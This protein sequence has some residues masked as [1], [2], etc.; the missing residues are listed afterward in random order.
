MNH[1]K[2]M[3]QVKIIQQMLMENQTMINSMDIKKLVI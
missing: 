3:L 2:K 1:K